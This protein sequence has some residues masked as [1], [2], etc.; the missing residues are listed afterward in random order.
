M[1]KVI[2]IAIVIVAVLVSVSVYFWISSNFLTPSGSVTS[3]IGSTTVVLLPEFTQH[4]ETNT[5]DYIEQAIA[6]FPLKEM[7][8]AGKTATDILKT[9]DYAAAEKLLPQIEQCT[10]SFAEIR[11]AVNAKINICPEDFRP[12]RKLPNFLAAQMIGKLLVI[13]GMGFEN[14]GKLD[15]AVNNYLLGVQFGSV[16]AGKNTSL[17]QKLVASALENIAYNPLKQFVLNNP[18]DSNNLKQIIHTLEKAEQNRV[19]F[20]EVFFSEKKTLQYILQNAKHYAQQDK[21][22]AKLTEPEIQRILAESEKIYAYLIQTFA[23]PYPQF[24]Q[25][26]LGSKLTAMVRKVHPIVSVSLPNFESAMI[27]E[28]STATDNRLIRI[29]AALELYY[30]ENRTYPNSLSELAPRFLSTVPKDYFS[31]SDFM[32]GLVSKTFYLYSIGPDMQDNH[33]RPVYDPT[34]GTVSVGDIIGR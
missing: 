31:D 1:K 22:L 12:E 33:E 20:T 13:Q 19:P 15:K 11:N 17:T 32:Y 23:L 5:Q 30:Q 24:R 10:A 7:L 8:P 14:Q 18:K 9:M 27:R 34:N 6:M 28:L 3:T 26:N 21:A 29:L 2:I 25:E 4:S 16:F